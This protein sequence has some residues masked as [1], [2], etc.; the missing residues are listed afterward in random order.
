M[1]DPGRMRLTRRGVA[2][3]LALVTVAAGAVACNRDGGSEAAAPATT[4]APQP[5]STTELAEAPLT[6]L[7][8]DDLDVLERSA[9]IVKVDN[10]PKARPQSGLDKAD[11]V[12]EERVE[13]SVVRFVAVFHSQDAKLVG[14]IRSVRSTDPGVV[15][16]FG[17][18]FAFSG[19]IA[20]FETQL[21]RAGVKMITERNNENAFILR[22]GRTRPYK[23]FASTAELRDAGNVKGSPPALFTRVEAGATFG[24]SG[25]GLPAAKATKATVV[26]GSRTT[27]VW[28][29]DAVAGRWKRTTNGTAHRVEGGAQLSFTTVILQRVPY[30]DTGFTD[31]SSSQVD[32]AVLVGRG[33]A[34]IL[35]QGRQVKAR[36]SKASLKAPT[37]YTDAATG[38]PI[39]I[40][41]GTTWVSLVP[42]DAP[43]TILPSATPG[44]STTT[45]RTG[46]L[47]ASTTTTRRR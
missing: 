10:D 40:P 19:G 20:A 30:R 27:A 42:T 29:Y 35:A 43:I 18:V 38:D 44:S 11:V 21:R 47:R 13:G 31:R 34:I 16:P 9:V 2:F 28:D 24:S 8:V 45:T 22:D 14:P 33:E 17:G 23:T 1:G 12:I 39:A 15:A 26:F 6:G 7:A 5:T 36:W 37:V 41:A 32:E 4:T 3:L 46:A 25:L